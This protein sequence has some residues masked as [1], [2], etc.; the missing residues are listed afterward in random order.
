MVLAIVSASG[1]EGV[2]DALTV[3]VRDFVCVTVTDS[4]GSGDCFRYPKA[5]AMPPEMK[6]IPKAFRFSVG[7]SIPAA[8]ADAMPIHALADVAPP[9]MNPDRR[10]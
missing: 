4:A 3:V 8:F 7:T 6:M 2:S 1:E 10:P 5:E 9:P